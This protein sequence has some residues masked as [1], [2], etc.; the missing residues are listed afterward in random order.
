MKL[1]LLVLLGACRATDA[2]PDRAPIADPSPELPPWSGAVATRHISGTLVDADLHP[3]A[4]LLHLRLDAPDGTVWTGLDR[5][6]GADGRFAFTVPRAARYTLF[7]TAPGRT[8][9]VVDVDVREADADVTVFALPCTPRPRRV[10]TLNGA[11][12]A[13]A[14]IDIA[15]TIIERT[16]ETGMF[17]VCVNALPLRVA[18][19]AAGFGAR[20]IAMNASDSPAKIE[21][22]R[23]VTVRGRVVDTAERPVANVAM[24]PVFEDHRGELLPLVVTSDGDG[25]FVMRE[26]P[27]TDPGTETV[28]T[29]TARSWQGDN[30]EGHDATVRVDSGEELVLYRMRTPLRDLIDL[31]S[32]LR[33]RVVR[34]G[35]PVRDAAISRVWRSRAI[36]IGHTGADG[37]F[38]VTSVF[39]ASAGLELR[40]VDSEGHTRQQRYAEGMVIELP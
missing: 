38:A 12:I 18:I 37:T 3:L 17:S 24:Q 15:G 11:P 33:G 31:E 9:R 35:A 39:G 29:Y 28:A 5:E 1:G 16:D 25:R 19:H 10:Q 4:G 22:R 26:L 30:L 20:A 27:E 32:T 2:T 21:L 13:N 7:A 34:R 40:V 8:S 23:G 6:L 14:R 36:E